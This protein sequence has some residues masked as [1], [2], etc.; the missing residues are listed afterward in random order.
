MRTD[1]QA[2][3]RAK[4][5]RA[6][7]TDA[8]RILWSRLKGRQVQGQHFRVQHPIGPYIADFV[9]VR[10]RLLVEVDGA[11]HSSEAER[12]HDERRRVF[13][14]SRGW[15]IL[16]FWN[17]DVYDNLDGVL[18]SISDCLPPR[19]RMPPPSC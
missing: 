12:A 13:L 16:R 9:C 6:E 17:S 15:T 14:E 3:A 10:E 7:L 19:G 11:T 8:E 5:L 2:R 4:A 18:R 1:S